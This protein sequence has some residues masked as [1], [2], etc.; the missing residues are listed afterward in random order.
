MCCA[1]FGG[2]NQV[3]AVSARSDGAYITPMRSDHP[4]L[5][6][7]VALVS[8]VCVVL[9]VVGAIVPLMPSTVFFI[10][11]AGCF[12]YASP[13]LE[14][15]LLSFSFI[16]APVRAWRERGAIALPAKLMASAGMA[17]GLALFAFLVILSFY[18]YAFYK[19]QKGVFMLLPS[20]DEYPERYVAFYVIFAICCFLI[21]LSNVVAI[22]RQSFSDIFFIDWVDR[23][24]KGI[25][26]Y[27]GAAT[28][29]DEE[30]RAE[31]LEDSAGGQRVQRA[32]DR[33]L[34]VL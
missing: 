3:K 20:E 2:A 5:R 14:A 27:L 21:L 6:P 24:Q 30:A 25:S 4:L 32:Y 7:L 34:G 22:F 1:R 16:G 33:A 28:E 13:R 18:I 12:A 10:A 26:F 29:Q 17:V 15:W 11:A 19:W 23:P 8:C 31:R 9:G